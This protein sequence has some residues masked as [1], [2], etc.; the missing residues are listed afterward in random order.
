VSAQAVPAR[1]IAL[2]AVRAWQ[3]SEAPEYSQEPTMPYSEHEVPNR[4]ETLRTFA[5]VATAGMQVTEPE[6]PNLVQVPA[7]PFSEQD[8]ATAFKVE[9]DAEIVS[10]GAVHPEAPG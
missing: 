7:T 3:I 10:T 5:A 9:V 6:A 2:V 8:V 4:A 1:L